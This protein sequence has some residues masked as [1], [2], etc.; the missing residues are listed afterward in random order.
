LEAPHRAGAGLFR[1]PAPASDYNLDARPPGALVLI[2]PT[3]AW[4]G[5]PQSSSVKTGHQPGTRAP[6]KM[7]LRMAPR[8]GHEPTLRG[9]PLHSEDCRMPGPGTLP[10]SSPVRCSVLPGNL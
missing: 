2:G 6:E 10:G 9:G 4:T 7:T 5:F 3:A 8:R 1:A